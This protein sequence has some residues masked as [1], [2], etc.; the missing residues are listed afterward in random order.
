MGNPGQAA[1]AFEGSLLD[2]LQTALRITRHDPRFALRALGLLRAQRLSARVRRNHELRG[3]HVPP[4]AIYS[5]TGR[6][7]LACTGCY[8]TILHR[9]SRPELPDDRVR[10]LLAE[11]RDLGVSVM[12]LAGGE[13]LLR[14]R[15]LDLT[16]E[17][18][19][20]LFLL[21]TNAL[22]LDDDRIEQLRKQKHVVPVLSQE[23]G[24][25]QTDERRGQG[26]YRSVTSAMARLKSRRVFF[27]TSTTLT[28]ENF[29]LATGEPHLRD[30]MRRGCRLFYYIN[31]VPV[32]PGTDDLQL[33]DDQTEEF[34]RR[35]AHYRRT[36][37]AL[38]VAFPHDE[39]ALGGCLAAGRGF[40]HINAIGDV[41]PCPFSPYSD[42]NLEE[43]SLEEALAS[44]LFKK[45]L[46]SGVALDERDGRCALWKRRSWV[47]TLLE[48]ESPGAKRD[49]RFDEDG[50]TAE[51]L[52]SG[53]RF[54]RGVPPSESDT[55]TRAHVSSGSPQPRCDEKPGRHHPKD[56]ASRV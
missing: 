7:N 9:S 39:V 1:A 44:P 48:E 8:A 20:I 26:T 4:F 21:F 14:E 11:A 17:T 31:Y 25:G 3:T 10:D 34:E 18:P 55:R 6:C 50:A 56:A 24:E 54:S 52:G 16:R 46:S 13:P 43:M 42:S 30:L 12:L 22:L 5:V 23:G 36:L 49:R 45:I 37:P 53:E 27:G 47:E 33:I 38:F 51:L 35:L 2:V 15:L 19:E 29:S 32:Q 40:I 41:E 28:R